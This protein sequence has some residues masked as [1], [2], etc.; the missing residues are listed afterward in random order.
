MMNRRIISI[1]VFIMMGLLIP[2]CSVRKDAAAQTVEGY[3]KALVAQDSNQISILSCMK[4]ESQA[5]M[6]LDSFQAV[7]VELEGLEC[8]NVGSDGEITLVD[9]QGKIIATYNEEIQEFAL[10]LRTYEVIKEGGEM[11]VCGYR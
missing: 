5:V 2:A 9:C 6:E 1:F 10:N 4:W 8:R 7:K 11:R 3:I